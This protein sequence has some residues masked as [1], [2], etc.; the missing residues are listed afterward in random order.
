MALKSTSNGIIKQDME[1]LHEIN[2]K[3]FRIEADELQYTLYHTRK[4]VNQKTKVPTVTE[5]TVGYFT[6]LERCLQ[7]MLR[8]ESTKHG[9]MN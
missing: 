9:N 7:R 3:A 4:G 1:I 2:W 6:S 8:I 5:V